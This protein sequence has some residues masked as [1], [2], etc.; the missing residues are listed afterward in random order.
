[1]S[2]QMASFGA[3]SRFSLVSAV[4][5]ARPSP[6]PRSPCQSLPVRFVA[7]IHSVPKLN[8]PS[9][10]IQ[11]A[12]VDGEFIDAASGATFDVHDPSTGKKIGTCP[13]FDKKDTEKA[14]TA[15]TEAL[16][17]WRK[18]LPR[19]RATLLR[20]WYDEMQKNAGDIATLI[21]WEVGHTLRSS[22]ESLTPIV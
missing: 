3:R 19:E 20:K 18:T 5:R 13:D 12:F 8:D 11:K 2:A 17:S 1:M 14:I 15:A 22:R 21:T 10:L 7:S 16:V 4:S 6:I 9:L